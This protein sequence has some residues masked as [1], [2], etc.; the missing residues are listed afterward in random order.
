MIGH[1]HLLWW[2][3][4]DYAMDGNLARYT[5][6]Q[7]ADA[8]E[9]P[10][11]AKQF[12]DSLVTCGLIDRNRGRGC[13]IHDWFD[14]CGELIHKRLRRQA[15]KRQKSADIVRHF[16]PKSA[17]SAPTVPDPTVPDPTKPT[18]RAASRVFSKPTATE[19][20]AYARE[21]AFVLDGQK[22]VDFYE[23]KGWLIGRSPMK[24]WRAAVRTWKRNG[25]GS[26]NGSGGYITPV[27]PAPKPPSKE[28]RELSDAE[29][30][31]MMAE[32]TK[33]KALMK[34]KPIPK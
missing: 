20:A 19:V 28:E 13:R 31:E 14:F 26:S 8:A 10:G 25:Y 24:D 6:Q 12:V 23:S 2:W 34:P 16:P 1:L 18:T 33:A 22:F 7:I 5:V 17:E 11:D 21:V 15:D 32:I 9:W 29:H 27:H 30:A 3:C 4:M